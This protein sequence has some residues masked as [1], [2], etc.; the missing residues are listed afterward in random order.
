MP[1]DKDKPVTD[2]KNT[3]KRQRENGSQT[4]E[5]GP[6]GGPLLR[7]LEKCRDQRQTQ[8]NFTGRGRI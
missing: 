5:D 2:T 6:A 8:Q 1:N 4:D 3:Q 7:C